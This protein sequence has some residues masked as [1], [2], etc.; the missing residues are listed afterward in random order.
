MTQE[1]K[2]EFSKQMKSQLVSPSYAFTLVRVNNG[3][4][5]LTVKTWI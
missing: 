4:P 3:L 2:H 1:M 5:C